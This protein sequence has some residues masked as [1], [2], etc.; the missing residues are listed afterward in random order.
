MY[1]VLIY[2]VLLNISFKGK[3]RPAKANFMLVKLRAVQHSAEPDSALTYTARS[4][5]LRAVL[6]SMKFFRIYFLL[7]AVL[8]SAESNTAQRVLYIVNSSA[9][10]KSFAEEC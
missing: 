9:K 6:T 7:K 10:T 4:L 3:E 1:V 2:R 8:V 5:T